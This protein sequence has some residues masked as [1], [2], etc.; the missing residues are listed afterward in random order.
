M[1]HTDSDIRHV[2]YELD[3][4]MQWLKVPDYVQITPEMVSVGIAMLEAPEMALGESVMEVVGVY[5]AMMMA[6]RGE[7]LPEYALRT[8]VTLSTSA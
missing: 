7:T 4:A 3:H 2:S 5:S 6:A 1:A 8:G